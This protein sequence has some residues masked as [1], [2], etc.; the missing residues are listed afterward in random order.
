MMPK[1]IGAAIA[2][3]LVVSTASAS[4]AATKKAQSLNAK[5]AAASASVIQSTD[6]DLFVRAKGNMGW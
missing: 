1:M 5:A 6:E 4:M 2:A 3:L